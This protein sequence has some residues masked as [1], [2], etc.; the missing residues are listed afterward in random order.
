MLKRLNVMP[1]PA[2]PRQPPPG[3]LP[4]PAH[5]PPVALPLPDAAV[6]PAS[7]PT[8]A[9]PPPSAA[10]LVS[11]TA[12]ARDKSSAV[13]AGSKR[14][15][16]PELAQEPPAKR[17]QTTSMPDTPSHLGATHLLSHADT[18]PSQGT[19]STGYVDDLPCAD[20]SQSTGDVTSW[21]ALVHESAGSVMQAS[22]DEQRAER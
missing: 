20:L 9:L 4:A 15:R 21:Q 3:P 17:S 19:I 13:H 7:T 5:H 10:A 14:P 8:A 11:A 22:A 18:E 1:G 2:P 12:P 16:S 6:P